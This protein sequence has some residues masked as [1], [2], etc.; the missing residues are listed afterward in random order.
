M[1]T[2]VQF[3]WAKMKVCIDGIQDLVSGV[4][5]YL[6]RPMPIMP[7]DFMSIDSGFF[8]RLMEAHENWLTLCYGDDTLE[9]LMEVCGK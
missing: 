3:S 9:K 7:M 6:Y 4:E 2:A 8:V 5:N 1:T